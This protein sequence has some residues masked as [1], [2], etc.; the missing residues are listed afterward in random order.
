V[1][2]LALKE[3][4]PTMSNQK[5]QDTTKVNNDKSQEAQMGSD[6]TV[7]KTD[8]A[9]IPGIS[10]PKTNPNPNSPF[11]NAGAR[12]ASD[13]SEAV[14]SGRAPKDGVSITTQQTD[15]HRPQDGAAPV[16]K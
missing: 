4:P 9:V 6:P 3:I 13:H 16:K 10:D 5:P 8:P 14:N 12:Q 2:C 1:H 11:Q 15:Q 7:P